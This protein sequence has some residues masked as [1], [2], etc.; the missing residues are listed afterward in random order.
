ME[1]KYCGGNKFWKNGL[2]VKKAGKIQLY[3]CKTCGTCQ[4]G[5]TIIEASLRIDEK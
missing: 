1:C 2:R 5:T 3:K 4:S